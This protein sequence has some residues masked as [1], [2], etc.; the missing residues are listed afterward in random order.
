MWH[1]WPLFASLLLPVLVVLL[2]NHGQDLFLNLTTLFFHNPN[3]NCFLT[4]TNTVLVILPSLE[5]LGSGD[6]SANPLV[7][8]CTTFVQHECRQAQDGLPFLYHS[9]SPEDGSKNFNDSLCFLSFQIIIQRITLTSSQC[10]VT[11][12]AMQRWN[13]NHTYKCLCQMLWS[14]H[15]GLMKDPCVPF[16]VKGPFIPTVTHRVVWPGAQS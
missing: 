4:L 15:V 12:S 13:H 2:F 10:F 6:G 5:R 8:R 16:L 3:H 14:A 9:W 1:H 7:S 11:Q